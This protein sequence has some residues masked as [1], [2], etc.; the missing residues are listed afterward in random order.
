MR[1]NIIDICD[2]QIDICDEINKICKNEIDKNEID[3]N[4]KNVFIDLKKRENF[5]DI[6]DLTTIV[7]HN[8]FDEN[9]KIKITKN[10]NEIDI[11]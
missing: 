7:I 9:T 8:I 4:V 2:N 6:I 3:E 5:V 1:Y 11:S 10:V